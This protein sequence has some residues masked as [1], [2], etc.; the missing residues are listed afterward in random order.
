MRS[1]SSEARY[2][3]IF[4]PLKFLMPGRMPLIRTSVPG[5]GKECGPLRDAVAR[6]ALAQMHLPGASV[7]AGRGQQKLFAQRPEAQQADAELALQSARA[8]RFQPPLD[9]IADVRRHV[10]EIRFAVRIP[11]HAL[12]VVLHAQVMLSLLLAAS[13]DDRLRTSVDAVLDELRHRLQR[14]ALRQ[15]DDRDRVPVIADAQIAARGRFGGLFV[16]RG[17]AVPSVEIAVVRPGL[18]SVRGPAMDRLR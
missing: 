1:R 4:S 2:H 15:R 3:W 16:A 10:V 9:G 8:L 5:S 18:S 7:L 11:A 13:D 17:H 12:A 14:I 6:V